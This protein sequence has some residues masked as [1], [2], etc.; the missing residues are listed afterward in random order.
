M[1]V[2]YEGVILFGVVF[3]FGY[4]FS[5]LS[6]YQGGPGLHRTIFQLYM[7]AVL[8]IYFAWFWSQGR[9]S[10]PMKTIGVRLVR[11]DGTQRPVSI[12]RAF[13]RYTVASFLFWGSLGLVWNASPW[14]L[15]AFFV[16]F[17]WAAFD[18]KR[19]TLYDLL[20][21]TLL[22]DAPQMPA[23]RAQARSCGS[24]S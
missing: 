14:W 17:G 12:G 1:S 24:G 4:A 18:R 5:A 7:F 2:V 21:G 3:F 8:G 22:V 13:W 6:Q 11:D 20:A 16:P 19:R 10:L 9:W 23:R 15:P